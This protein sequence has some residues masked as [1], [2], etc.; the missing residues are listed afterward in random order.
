M[1]GIVKSISRPGSNGSGSSPIFGGRGGVVGVLAAVIL[2]VTLQTGLLQFNVNATWQVGVVGV[3]L[4]LVL[5]VDRFAS[6]RA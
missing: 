3:L 1:S 4:F 2:V 6:R 5:L